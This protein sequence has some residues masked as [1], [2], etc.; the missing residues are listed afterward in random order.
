[1]TGTCTL[2]VRLQAPI[3]S[4]GGAGSRWDWRTT[5]PRPTKSALTGL[6]ANA[7]GRTRGSDNADLSSL[8]FAVRADRPG[9][10]EMDF[11]TAGG[12]TMPHPDGPAD[13]ATLRTVPYQAPGSKPS[14]P[15]IRRATYLA[16]AAFLASLTG[17]ASLLTAIQ[18]A[19]AR[20]ARPLYLGRA[21]NPPSHPLPYSLLD[22]D[23]HTT[24]ADTVPLLECA[25][26][27]H[28]AAWVQDTDPAGAVTYE[29]AAGYQDST[30]TYEPVTMTWHLT[31]PP[32]P[33][34]KETGQ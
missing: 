17:P 28:P 21:A 5:G 9:R 31:N 19:L 10:T 8:L 23:Q 29:Q 15:L 13:D 32:H 18:E 20:P 3:Q 33:C 25:T 6:V 30:Y 27:P 4:W 22:G 7:L 11:R 1:M 26:T 2:L 24:W 12:G 34:G 14:T 16:D